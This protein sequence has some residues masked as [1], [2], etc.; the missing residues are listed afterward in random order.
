VLLP[1][2]TGLLLDEATP[3]EIAAALRLLIEDPDLRERLGRAAEEH[4]RTKFD[5]VLNARA[6]EAVYDELLGVE[7]APP[8]KAG[9]PEPDPLPAG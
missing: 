6:V 2:K 4:A 5:P 8:V 9:A 3:E 7:P 1:G